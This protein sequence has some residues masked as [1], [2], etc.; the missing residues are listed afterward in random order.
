MTIVLAAHLVLTVLQVTIFVILLNHVK[1]L[2]VVLKTTRLHVDILVTVLGVLMVSIVKMTNDHAKKIRVFNEVIIYSIQF[3]NNSCCYAGNCTNK[4][5][6]D[7]ECKCHHGYEGKHCE[8]TVDF[9]ANATCQN[10]GVCFRKFLNFT[11]NCLPG[12]N[13]LYCEITESGT[14]VR[15]YVSKSNHLLFFI[16]FISSYLKVLVILLF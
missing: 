8:L 5:M 13:G 15:K 10:R 12:Y 11:C 3:D 16:S 2:V 9:C 7:F 1:I 4:T 14:T 6:T